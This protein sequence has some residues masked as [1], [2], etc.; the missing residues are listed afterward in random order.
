MSE[1]ILHNSNALPESILYVLDPEID[2]VT[3]YLKKIEFNSSRILF[4]SNAGLLTSHS[5]FDE[6]KIFDSRIQ[7]RI[8]ICIIFENVSRLLVNGEDRK[9]LE[10][11][12]TEDCNGQID[13]IECKENSFLVNVSGLPEP[14][15][16]IN[17]FLIFGKAPFIE[18]GRYLFE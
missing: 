3:T 11:V 15:S 6:S 14:Y 2:W 7:V 16:N 9:V 12:C 10:I 8:E 1:N 4:F 17:E 18:F 5:K 13:E